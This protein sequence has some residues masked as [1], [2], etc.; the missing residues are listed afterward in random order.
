MKLLSNFF[1]WY[2]CRKAL[3]YW[4]IV[5]FDFLL[6]FFGGMFVMWLRHPMS[7]MLRHMPQL[8]HTFLA[9]G[10]ANVIGFRIFHTYSGILRYSQFGDLLRVLYS[11]VLSL[12]IALVFN[13]TVL[14][15]G[16]S[17]YFTVIHGRMIVI[18][19]ICTAAMMCVSRVVIRLLFESVLVGKNAKSVLIYGTHAGAIAYDQRDT[20]YKTGEIPC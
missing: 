18:I 7:E 4:C 1:N 8:M 15:Y 3:P 9:F 2:F 10:V 14:H 17:S 20:Q 13:S 19:Y 11:S 6:C 5:I 12:L 16:L